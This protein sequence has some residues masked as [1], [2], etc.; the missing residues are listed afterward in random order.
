[1][2][3]AGRRAP[4]RFFEETMADTTRR[5]LRLSRVNGDGKSAPTT[6]TL[7]LK[8]PAT[9]EELVAADGTP[10]VFL[11]LEPISE[12][13]RKAIIFEHRRLEKD[14]AGGKQLYEFIDLQAANDAIFCRVVKGWSGLAGADD[15][16]LV[17]TDATKLLLDHTIRGQVNKK[18]FGT[19][20]V[21]VL[22][23]SFR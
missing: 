17:C 22:A 21:E 20:A 8:D 5:V 13:D 12:E 19:E 3:K 15:R 23:E 11:T 6:L 14:P 10:E 7:V 1:M 2:T 18:I 4:G 16:P 9:G